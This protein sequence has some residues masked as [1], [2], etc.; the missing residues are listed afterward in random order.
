[1]KPRKCS[2]LLLCGNC[3][4]NTHTSSLRTRKYLQEARRTN[5]AALA[6]LAFGLAAAPIFCQSAVAQSTNDQSTSTQGNAADS[7]LYIKVRLSNPVKMSKLKSGDVVQGSLTGD[8]YSTDRKL[9]PSGSTVR[10]TVDHLEKRKRTPNDHWPWV[11]NAFTPRHENYPVFKDATVVQDQGETSVQVSM[12]SSSRMR[13]VHAKAKKNAPG[14]QS[15]SASSPDTTT[16]TTNAAV[17]VNHSGGKKPATPT[18]VLEA[19]GIQNSPA[20][21]TT[22]DEAASPEPD[23]TAIAAL[24]AGTHCKILLLGTVSASKSKPG[25]PVRARLLEPV[26]LNSK[27]ALP[28]GTLIEGKVVKQTPPRMLSRAG[29]LYLTFT[30]LTLPGGNHFPIAASLAGIELNERS[31]TKMDAEGQ[32]HGEHPGKA[33]LAINLGMTVGISKVA[34]DGLQLV[35]EA[36][37]STATD[38]STAGVGRIA[39]SCA[40]A[41]YMATRHGRDIVLP[42]FT[43]MNISFDRPL[44]LGTSP[45]VAASPG[46]VG[47][48]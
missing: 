25:D 32:L 46:T 33:W 17:E 14:P 4:A 38:A 18:L 44:T 24:P 7:G 37:V 28:A 1:M 19:F 47:G 34:D 3:S 30:D 41:I 12:I 29:S 27:L 15:A 31:H 23:A 11:V 43:E 22:A 10:L 9:F 40:S 36:I 13:E 39:S 26:L 48:K 2:W 6:L 8:V 42:R 21:P 16:G 35:I 20:S 5:P 45:T